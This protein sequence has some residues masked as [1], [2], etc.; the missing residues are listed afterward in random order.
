MFGQS[1]LLQIT[2]KAFSTTFTRI[3]TMAASS[4]GLP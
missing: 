4:L 1:Y 3:K 2:S